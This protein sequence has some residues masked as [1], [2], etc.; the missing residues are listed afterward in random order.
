[1]SNLAD[2]PTVRNIQDRPQ[3]A[4]PA[5]TSMTLDEL[6]AL[7]AS[8]GAE[9]CGVVSI[10][11]PALAA[12]REYILRAFPATRTA[13]AILCRMHREP[14]RS[15]ERSISNLEFHRVGHEIDDIAGR[16]VGKLEDAGIAALNPAMA[17]PME[18]DRFPGRGWIVSHKLVAQA[19]GLGKI[20][21]HRNVI[22]PKFGSFILLGTVLLE[23]EVDRVSQ[24][25][26]FNPCL[27]CKLCVAAC[28]VGAIKSDGYFDFSACLN[29]NYQQFMGGFVNWIEDIADSGS[30][31]EYSQRFSYAESVGRWQSLSY[32][33]NY[34]AAYCLAV[35][36]A[37]EDV[38][39][40]YLASQK[41][42]LDTVVRPLQ[43]KV[44]PLY[45]IRDSDAAKHAQ[46]RF[47]HKRLRWVRPGGRANSIATFLGGLRL[48]FQR[49]KA[50][51]V[52]ATYHFTFTGTETAE[53]TVRISQKTLTV[54]PHHDG[55]PDVK[56]TADAQTW[57]RFINHEISIF[58]CLLTR[59]VKVR[60]SLRLL[61][62]FGQ[63]FAT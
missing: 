55:T 39:G 47:P 31:R 23:I 40:P 46:R 19:A 50:A 3:T 52:S 44:E 5:K 53:A 27:S 20:G 42:F 51:D 33:P 15:T 7:A 14:I 11:D 8:C 21:I 1:M 16:I 13:L 61:G 12:D 62:S 58:R 35:C 60:G 48:T 18:T 30:A 25:I 17:F 37:G 22:H 10:D 24:A 41:N 2:H 9:D 29:H 43:K 34:N 36:P 57:I 56:V 26:D 54:L 63:C 59:K 45:V 38:I 28:P 6:K 49:E 4:A 32:G